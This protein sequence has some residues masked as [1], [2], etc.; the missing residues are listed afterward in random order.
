M[1]SEA[2]TEEE[3]MKFACKKCRKLIFTDA[4]LEE[5]TS[6]VKKIIT[7]PHKVGDNKYSKECSSYFIE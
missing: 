4:N 2:K 5:H 1:E 6:K 7:R 3:P